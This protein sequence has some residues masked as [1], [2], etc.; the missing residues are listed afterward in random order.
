MIERVLFISYLYHIISHVPPFSQGSLESETPQ[1]L[2]Q[3]LVGSG[4][5]GV[6]V[7]LS[8]TGTG[9]PWAFT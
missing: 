8:Q 2:L 9:V 1:N 7:Q 3:R 4:A 6:D 5:R